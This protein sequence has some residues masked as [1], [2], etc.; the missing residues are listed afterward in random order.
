[1]IRHKEKDDEA[2]G[3]GL[4]HL[5]TR[6]RLWRDANG[7]IVNARRPNRHDGVKKRQMTSINGSLDRMGHERKDSNTSQLSA[8]PSPPTSSPSTEGQITIDHCDNGI[9]Q[10]AWPPVDPNSSAHNDSVDPFE[11]LCNASWGN[12]PFQ[13]FMG[14]QDGLPYDDIFKPD[15]GMYWNDA[16][17]EIQLGFDL[18]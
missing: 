16:S 9:F 12:Q 2:G 14:T 1:M 4:G 6:K 18:V 10:D 5:A 7:N 15:T 17:L 8:P 3:E 13:S 11:F